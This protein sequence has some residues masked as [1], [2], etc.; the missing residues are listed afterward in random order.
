MRENH[1]LDQERN[2]KLVIN[3]VQGVEM[4]KKLNELAEMAAKQK[5]MKDKL[6]R[7][8]HESNMICCKSRFEAIR[9]SD[10]IGK[11]NNTTNQGLY[12]DQIDRLSNKKFSQR[13]IKEKNSYR[14]SGIPDFSLRNARNTSSEVNG[15]RTRFSALVNNDN[16]I[17]FDDDDHGDELTS[18]SH[19]SNVFNLK[20]MRNIKKNYNGK[21]FS[22]LRYDSIYDGNENLWLW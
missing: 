5:Q 16:D 6:A 20:K 3:H 17:D 1:L 13:F 18:N 7:S 8:E 15:L 4:D 9:K 14:I 2:S 22:T 21:N 19:R 12:N 10:S 11:S